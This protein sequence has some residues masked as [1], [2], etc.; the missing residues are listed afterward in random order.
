MFLLFAH[1]CWPA[2]INVR[3]NAAKCYLIL[4]DCSLNFWF[5]GFF[6]ISFFLPGTIQQN[7]CMLKHLLSLASE[8]SN[9]FYWQESIPFYY[10]EDP[11][12]N[13]AISFAHANNFICYL[14]ASS[15]ELGEWRAEFKYNTQ[16]PGNCD[17]LLLCLSSSGCWGRFISYPVSISLPNSYNRLGGARGK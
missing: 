14:V 3:R 16:G 9:Q 10:Q 7:I 17:T 13:I 8:A 6:D 12:D 1:C 15:S 4:V 11:V 5:L 2:P